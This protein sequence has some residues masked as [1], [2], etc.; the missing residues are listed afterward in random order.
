MNPPVDDVAEVG[1]VMEGITVLRGLS[2]TL[3]TG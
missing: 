1:S 2:R 3:T